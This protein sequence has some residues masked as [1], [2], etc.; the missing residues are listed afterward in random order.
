[1]Q[2]QSKSEQKTYSLLGGILGDAYEDDGRSEKEDAQ[3]KVNTP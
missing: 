3:A 2:K 1:M